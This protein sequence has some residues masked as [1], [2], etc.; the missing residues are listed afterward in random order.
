LF[1]EDASL[2]LKSGWIRPED[3]R[4]YLGITNFFKIV[5]RGDLKSRV[6]RSTR[7][8]LEEKWSGNLLDILFTSLGFFTAHYGAYLDKRSP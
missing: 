4:K 7:A 1:I 6:I 5:G 2:I 3:T 8:Y